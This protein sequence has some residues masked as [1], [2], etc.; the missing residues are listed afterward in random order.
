M[1]A[2]DETPDALTQQ[3]L[4]ALAHFQAGFLANASHELRRPMTQIISLHQLILEGLCDDPEEEQ[5]FLRQSFE[6]TQ[7]VLENLDLLI[8]ISKL[9]VGRV[10]PK[11]QILHLQDVFAQLQMQT[12]ILAEN[13]NCRLTVQMATE[14]T[15]KSD[16][17]WLVQALRLLIEGA[18]T[19]QSEQIQVYGQGQSDQ[20]Q[21]FVITDSAT[22]AWQ[23][24][25]APDQ[26][27][28]PQAVG[29]SPG[30]CQQ[31][32]AQI[33]MALGGDLAPSAEAPQQFILTLPVPDQPQAA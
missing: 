7:R 29:F 1:I 10:E 22:A 19:A 13:R 28:V 27:Q 25:P 5:Q 14:D 17:D 6:A 18:I 16:I 8:G 12:Q 24:A 20:L 26:P 33:L 32:A 21:I 4:Q 2:V 11:L 23:A 30:Y 3:R 9:G 31:L 15:L